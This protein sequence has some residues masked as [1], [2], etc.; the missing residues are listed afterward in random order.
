MVALSKE[1]VDLSSTSY[2]EMLKE[3]QTLTRVSDG[4]TFEATDTISLPAMSASVFI[5]K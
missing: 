3:G 4:K 2:T 5:V 1:S